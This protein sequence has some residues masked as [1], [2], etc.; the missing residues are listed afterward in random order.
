MNGSSTV[1]SID[2]WLE[3]LRPVSPDQVA[4]LEELTSDLPASDAWQLLIEESDLLLALSQRPATAAIVSAALNQ[5][6]GVGEEVLLRVWER[7]CAA[8]FQPPPLGAQ[9]DNEWLLQ[10]HRAAVALHGLFTRLAGPAITGN[11]RFAFLLAG[12]E[13]LARTH[14]RRFHFGQALPTVIAQIRG[15]FPRLAA[16]LSGFVEGTMPLFRVPTVDERDQQRWRDRIDKLCAEIKEDIGLRATRGLGLL[17]RIQSDNNRHVFRPIME[18]LE[19]ADQLP[20]E[21]VSLIRGLSGAELLDRHPLQVRAGAGRIEGTARLD[22]IHYYDALAGKAQAVLDLR[23]ELQGAGR[24]QDA[25]D[26]GLSLELARLASQWRTRGV[27]ARDWLLA[28]LLSSDVLLV[29]SRLPM[30]DASVIG[31]SEGAQIGPACLFAAI[32][33]ATFA[34]APCAVADLDGSAASARGLLQAIA[35]QAPTFDLDHAQA[36]RRQLAEEGRFVVGR[37][38]AGVSEQLFSG[39]VKLL[40]SLNA[41]SSQ[42]R[43]DLRGKVS[44]VEA[45]LGER[46]TPECAAR[47]GQVRAL[48]EN[49]FLREA[50]RALDEFCAA[51]G[52]SPDDLV[53]GA[54]RHAELEGERAAQERNEPAPTPVADRAAQPLALRLSEALALELQV[55]AVPVLPLHPSR[56]ELPHPRVPVLGIRP[57]AEL[58][59]LDQEFR[60]AEEYRVR[61]LLDEAQSGFRRILEADPR[62]VRARSQLV[63]VLEKLE[64]RGAAIELLADG[65]DL[66]PAHVPFLHQIVPLLAREG[67]L[68]EARHYAQRGLEICRDPSEEVGFVD[69]LVKV[70]RQARNKEAVMAHLRRLVQLAPHTEH[71]RN[72]L[73][74]L[75]GSAAPLPQMTTQDSME[76]LPWELPAESLEISPFLAADIQEPHSLVGADFLERKGPEKAVDEAMRLWIKAVDAPDTARPGADAEALRTGA[77]LLIAVH[78]ECPGFDYLAYIER[79]KR[80]GGYH[81]PSAK[82]HEDALRRWISYYAARKGDDFF[83]KQRTEPARA[84]YLEH[85]RVFGRLFPFSFY[86]T[87]KYIR[88]S[89]PEVRD[90]ITWARDYLSQFNARDR[91]RHAP[92]GVVVMFTGTLEHHLLTGPRRDP[93]VEQFLSDFLDVCLSNQAAR[94]AVLRLT[95]DPE[96]PVAKVLW[97]AHHGALVRVGTNTPRD[98][99]E[100]ALQQRQEHHRLNSHDLDFVLSEQLPKREYDQAILLLSQVRSRGCSSA[101]QRLLERVEEML[102]LAERFDRARSFEDKRYLASDASLRAREAQDS[103]VAEPTTLGRVHLAPVAFRLN[104]DLDAAFQRFQERS[105]PVIEVRAIKSVRMDDCIRAD[106]HVENEGLS[107]AERIRL[108]FRAGADRA[109]IGGFELPRLQSGPANATVQK[110]DLRLETPADADV[111]EVVVGGTYADSQGADPRDQR[112]KCALE[113]LPAPDLRMDSE[114]LRHRRHH[115]GQPPVQGTRPARHR[116]PAG[117]RES[118]VPRVGGHVRPEAQRQVVHSALGRRARSGLARPCVAPGAGHVRRRG[119]PAEPVPPHCR[120]H[121][122]GGA[123]AP[124][125]RVEPHRR[126]CAVRIARAFARVPEVPGEGGH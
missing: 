77:K 43:R 90:A 16:E 38:W 35:Q 7:T 51:Q 110:T 28:R 63:L 6:S 29:R 75:S 27:D 39:D 83:L 54:Y 93:R 116:H 85:F 76:L 114:P 59:L 113:H 26:E 121:R 73:A 48:A 37:L 52:L 31:R 30:P 124:Q 106:I 8:V 102:R 64:Q 68:E 120:E 89:V 126:G 84:Y 18:A 118:L 104:R 94:A 45:A 25:A 12:I 33:P 98:W 47:L 119:R 57:E 99:V 111:M 79:R 115:Q 72:L 80:A 2:A 49:G 3:L 53:E 22:T 97:D 62:H 55:P 9:I 10:T 101:D 86:T 71:Y 88:T 5:V 74:L 24:V 19:S 87:D 105:T 46:K 103:I 41:G 36:V 34:A 40:E 1:N 11:D 125:D 78:D 21:I 117:G 65:I 13:V 61:N 15:T 107:P 56:P 60:Q 4:A 123:R 95:G 44:A 91:S 58:G 100:R 82:N 109:E 23:L 70:E 96:H 108:V 92:E 50:R 14:D 122:G 67:R 69:D 17:S 112:E 20:A 32:E 42:Q 81:V 66:S